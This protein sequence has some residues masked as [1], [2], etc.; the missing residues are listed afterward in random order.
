MYFLTQRSQLLSTVLET[1]VDRDRNT[2]SGQAVYDQG[3]PKASDFL[4]SS[5]LIVFT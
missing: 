4:C 2:L 5:I 3:A 1:L